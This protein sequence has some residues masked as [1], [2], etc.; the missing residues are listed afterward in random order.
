MTR[1]K[2]FR[3]VGGA[4]FAASLVGCAHGPRAGA[5]RAALAVSTVEMEPLEL[6]VSR[7]GGGVQIEVYDA[8]SLF[9]EG[10]QHLDADRFAEA[11]ASYER[12][13]QNFAESPYAP[14]A[15]YNA[16]L[17]YEGLSRY[18][19][20]AERYRRVVEGFAGSK[21]AKDAALRLGACYAELGR[22]PAS[23][24]VFERALKRDDLNLSER[25][26]AMSRRALGLYEIGDHQVAE[27]GFRDTVAYYQAH[28]EEERLESP[29]FVA[30]AQFYQAHIGHRRFRDLPLRLPQK[31]LEQDIAA[32]SRQFLT[33]QERYVDTIRFKD[34][35]WASAAGFQVGA[36][37]RE[38]Y[39]TLIKAPLPKELDNDLKKIIYGE[40]LKGNLRNLLEKARGVLEKNLEMAGRVGIKNGWIEKSS[41]QLEELSK[42]LLALDDQPVGPD[43]VTPAEQRQPAAPGVPS[44]R[45]RPDGSSRPRATL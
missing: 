44:P 12:I 13:V 32:L 20:A 36:L 31:Q 38:L 30:M 15:L 5:G 26:E 39:D 1:S 14:P 4:L 9:E 37:Y 29:F 8:K 24:E 23:I 16:A 6:E 33:A 41:E 40:M 2:A 35:T 11:A 43:A 3:L 27:A 10:G 19:D 34:P 18:A 25:I 21:V 22:W 28:K 17:S 42:L 7:S 45:T